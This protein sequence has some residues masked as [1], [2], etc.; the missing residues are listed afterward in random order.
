MYI[1]RVGQYNLS[2]FSKPKVLALGPTLFLD[3]N[4]IT[5]NDNDQITTWYDDSGNDYDFTAIGALKPRLKKAAN[6]INNNNVLKF[7][8]AAMNSAVNLSSFISTSADT[9]FMVFKLISVDTD[10]EYM[11]NNDCAIGDLNGMWG[12][13]FDTNG[14]VYT[15]YYSSGVQYAYNTISTSTAYTLRSRHASSNIYQC[16]NNG[17]ENSDG[18]GNVIT[19]NPVTIGRSSGEGPTYSYANIDI[20]EI[21]IFNTNL[22]TANKAIVDGY[23]RKKYLTY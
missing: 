19:S 17:S 6:G 9:F 12:V 21:I 10:E 7:N 11:Y 14:Y 23:L 13:Y 3:A 16:I 1:N 5:G 4:T 2:Q 20:A 8:G 15:Y 18:A 22:S